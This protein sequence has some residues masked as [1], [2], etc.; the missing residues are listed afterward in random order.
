MQ[1]ALLRC[2]VGFDRKAVYLT[3]AM[4]KSY[5]IDRL[6]YWINERQ[7]IT[8][9]RYLG[10]PKPWT[11]DPILQQFKFCSVRREDDA[12]TRWIEKHWRAPHRS[13]KKA[14]FSMGVARLLNY[15]PTLDEIGYP[16]PWRPEA[17]RAKLQRRKMAKEQVFTGA[18][19]ITNAGMSMSKVN[20][21]VHLLN[22]LHALAD[23]P[24]VGDTLATAHAKLRKANCAGMGSFIAAQV[25]ADAKHMDLLADAADW[26][27]WAAP[28]PGSLRG[29]A[30][31]NGL[32]PVRN[33]AEFIEWLQTLR[34][35]VQPRLGPHV[36]RLCL[37]DLQSTLCEFDKME[38]TTWGEG[39]PRSRYPGV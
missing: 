23:P 35:L 28:G 33:G 15:T 38:R 6:A 4:E 39:R 37:Q 10:E 11:Q 20:T 36:P 25:V 24:C 27:D 21:V 2:E 22:N 7:R 17:V 12:V 19:M 3:P 5:P 32:P 31:I 13:D 1:D 8:D 9:A 26:W 14:W 34:E 16:K 18:Y 29:L 30:R